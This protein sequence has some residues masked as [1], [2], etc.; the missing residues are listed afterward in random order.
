MITDMST[1]DMYRIEEAIRESRSTQKPQ[2]ADVFEPCPFCG[3]IN[4]AVK[5]DQTL[6]CGN[7]YW[8]IVHMMPKNECPLVDQFGIWHSSA[9]YTTKE[10]A[11][12]AWNK[13]AR[14]K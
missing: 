5:Q 7:K 3:G 1:S 9:K 10:K 11:I 4:V 13:Q 6:I 8:Y 12:A 14:Q 2:L